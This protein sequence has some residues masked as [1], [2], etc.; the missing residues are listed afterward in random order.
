V[1]LQMAGRAASYGQS[2]PGSLAYWFRAQ[3]RAQ[4]LPL[5]FMTGT[6]AEYHWPAVR[7]V[8]ALVSDFSGFREEAVLIRAEV[9]RGGPA[10]HRAI[11]R[12][13]AIVNE[14]FELRTAAFFSTVLEGGLGVV[15][16]FR[17]YEFGKH[18]GHAHWH[19]LLYGGEKSLILQRLLDPTLQAPTLDAMVAAEAEAALGVAARQR[20]LFGDAVTAEHPAGRERSATS[21]AALDQPTS[22]WYSDR[23]AGIAHRDGCS[24]AVCADCKK[25]DTR[26][27]RTDT[28]TCTRVGNIDRWPPPEGQYS[29]LFM[30]SGSSTPA[31]S[32][33]DPG[34]GRYAVDGVPA[35]LKSTPKSK[36]KTTPKT[37]PKPPR[38][39]MASLNTKLYQLRGADERTDDMV[40]TMRC[41][42]LAVRHLRVWVPAARAACDTRLRFSTGELH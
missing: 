7:R 9:G 28:A 16:H 39:S 29:S 15:Q 37:T 40:C 32:A 26:A 12:F 17:K 14:L 20:E 8:L 6:A 35:V 38:L 22:M 34:G 13:P 27:L 21:A 31:A 19:S 1:S 18:A 4:E 36:P 5:F 23:Q 10:L 41:H 42:R 24:K 11:T 25:N 2:H 3:F 30:R 33:A